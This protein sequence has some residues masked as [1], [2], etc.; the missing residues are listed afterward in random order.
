MGPRKEILVKFAAIIFSVLVI[1]DLILFAA[2][3]IRDLVFWTVIVIS[4]VV[5]YA[6]MPAESS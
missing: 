4:A 3:T 1:A 5:A 2:G 6:F